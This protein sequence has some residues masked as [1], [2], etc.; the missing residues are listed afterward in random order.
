MTRI[1][2]PL[3]CPLCDCAELPDGLRRVR[4]S[5]EWDEQT[6]PVGLLRNHRVASGTWGRIVVRDGRLRFT[7]STAPTLHVILGAGAFQAIPPDVDHR[8]EPL[9]SV[10]F[11]IDFMAVD[12]DEFSG[13]ATVVDSQVPPDLPPDQQTVDESGDPACW[14][15]LVCPECGAVLEGGIHPHAATHAETL[16]LASPREPGPESAE[17]RDQGHYCIE[18]DLG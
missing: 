5:P 4:S 10:R 9:G 7:A 14:A 13:H 15:Q 3:D 1:G 6:I 12:R 8:V 16:S 17:K 2:T 18:R 11:C